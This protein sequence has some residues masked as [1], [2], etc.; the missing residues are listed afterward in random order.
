MR[1]G[2][3][4]P[5]IS[6]DDEPWVPARL[7]DYVVAARELGFASLGANDHLVFARPWLDGIVALAGAIEASGP[8]R[9]AT[10]VALPVLRGAPALAKTAA[11]L[12]LLSGGRFVLGIGPGS[13]AADYELAGMA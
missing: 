3:H 2:A 6:F 13:S 11:A 7:R 9:L 8:L 4:L 12:D 5:L 1:F 10:T